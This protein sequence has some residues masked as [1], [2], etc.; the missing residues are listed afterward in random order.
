[1]NVIKRG[2]ETQITVAFDENIEN[3]TEILVLFGQLNEVV[4]TKTKEECVIKGNKLTVTLTDADTKKFSRT[5]AIKGS[6]YVNN[7]GVKDESDIF[8]IYAIDGQMG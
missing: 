2:F 8:L 6:I 5:S 1:M 4:I 3:F 7:N